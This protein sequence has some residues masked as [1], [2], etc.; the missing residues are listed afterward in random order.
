MNRVTMGHGA[1]GELMQE[2]IGKHIVPFLPDFPVEVPLKS[3]DDSA[4]VDGIVFT[5]DAHTVKPLFFPG[6]DIGALAICGA[7][8]DISVMGAKALAM[9]CALVLEEGLEFDVLE[10]VMKSM[11][12][13]SALTGVPIVTGDTKVVEKGAADG[14]IITTSAVGRRSEYLDHNFKVASSSRKVRSNWLTDD[15]VAD[16]D[17]IIV[18]GTVGDHGIAILSFREGYG[19]ETK[20]KSDVAPL[21]ELVEE[22]LS[23]GGA[24]AM[25]DPTRGGLANTLNEWAEK[26]GVGIEIDEKAIPIAEPVRNACEMLGLDPLTIGNEGKLVVAVVPEMAEEV[27]KAMKGSPLGKGAE[28]IGKATSKHKRVVLRTEIGGK[29]ILERPIGDPVPRIC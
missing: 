7:I 3:F 12:K 14:M 5:T 21:N 27:L 2:L 26:S 10:R 9:S 11:G 13:Y 1:G 17:V 6:G 8:N 29:R 15:N 22:I 19:F 20:V 28:I 24:V 16:G 18:S 25:K 23:V 4:V